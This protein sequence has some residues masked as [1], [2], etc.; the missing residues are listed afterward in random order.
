MHKKFQ[1]CGTSKNSLKNSSV[2]NRL[3]MSNKLWVAS[4]MDGWKKCS[5][6][7]SINSDLF[8][9][10][11]QHRKTVV[12][13]SKIIASSFLCH[14]LY[15][16]SSLS[17]LSVKTNVG[18]S[19]AS[20]GPAP[21]QTM[22][23]LATRVLWRCGLKEESSFILCLP[24]RWFSYFIH[25]ATLTHPLSPHMQCPTGLNYTNLPLTSVF[26]TTYSPV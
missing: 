24:V 3:A 13:I 21:T 25:S 2:I 8:F 12:E 7:N 22:L 17:P 10:W 23:N 19:P 5:F 1:S 15:N 20:V 18:K 26:W 6:T 14:P 4:V 16:K 9:S 11:G